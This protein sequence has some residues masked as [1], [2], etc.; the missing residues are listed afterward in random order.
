MSLHRCLAA[1]SIVVV[2]VMSAAPLRAQSESFL[3]TAEVLFATPPSGV[4][5]PSVSEAY[6]SAATGAE[7]V[8]ADPPVRRRSSP[9][10]ILGVHATT[11]LMQGLDAH[12]TFLA[13]DRGGVEVNPAVSLFARNREAFTAMKVGVAAGL[14]YATDRLARKHPMRALVLAAAV[15][16]AYALV[17][18]RNYRVAGSIR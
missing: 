2:T 14:I 7:P 10:W 13:M 5:A 17:V 1:G 6:E 12:S 18:A 11:A 8:T 4:F 9:G 15:N 16:S 3:P